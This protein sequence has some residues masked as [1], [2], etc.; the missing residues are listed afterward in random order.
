MT[1]APHLV[2]T[3]DCYLCSFFLCVRKSYQ[4]YPRIFHTQQS[5]LE[6]A[7]QCHVL[8]AVQCWE[9]LSNVL[10]VTCWRVNTSGQ[11]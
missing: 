8:Y 6:Q 11:D 5:A 9:G 2:L 4:K 7:E 10:Q 3:S 1:I